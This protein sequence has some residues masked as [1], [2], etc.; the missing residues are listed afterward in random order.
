M[1]N[2]Q[3]KEDSIVINPTEELDLAEQI[4]ALSTTESEKKAA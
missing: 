2:L 3:K 1:I 4:K